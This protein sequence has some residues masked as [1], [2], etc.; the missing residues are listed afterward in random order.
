MRVTRIFEKIEERIKN[1]QAEISGVKKMVLNWAQ[2][3][4]LQHHRQEMSGKSHSSIGYRL[5]QKTVLKKVKS[6]TLRLFSTQFP[7][8]LRSTKHLALTRLSPMD[9]LSG[10]LP[11]PRG[12]SGS[13]SASTWSCWRWPPWQRWAGCRRLWTQY[14]PEN[15]EWVESASSGR[16][17]GKHHRNMRLEPCGS[18]GCLQSLKFH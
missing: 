3:Q 5:A 13:C 11:C 1:Q 7:K 14:I 2:R 4:A 17:C 6:R 10:A 12:Q 16:T 18:I 9:L 15:S 8:F